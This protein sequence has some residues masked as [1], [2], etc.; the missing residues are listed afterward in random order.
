MKLFNA[1]GEYLSLSI[2]G[3]QFPK[4][5]SCYYDA[6]WLSI[7]GSVHLN[8]KTWTFQDPCLLNFEALR[9]IDWLKSVSQNA[10]SS[11]SIGFI[12]PNLEFELLE[13]EK[14]RVYFELEARPKW[15]PCEGAGMRDL[16]FEFENSESM[17]TAAVNALK[18]QLNLYP[19]RALQDK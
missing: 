2:E 15:A 6:N 7:A 3:Y 12:E 4:N 1:D 13:E 5:D 9:L 8:K 18:A 11:D 14:I 10:P 19:V 17:I 16:F